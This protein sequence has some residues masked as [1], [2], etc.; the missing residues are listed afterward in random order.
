MTHSL[1]DLR[2]RLDEASGATF[3][4]AMIGAVSRVMKSTTTEEGERLK[5]PEVTV[6]SA[7]LTARSEI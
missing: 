2:K 3:S 7:T 1:T 6:S 4:P 5:S